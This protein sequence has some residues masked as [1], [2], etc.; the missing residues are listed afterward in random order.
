MK[1]K[2]P[3]ARLFFLGGLL[4]L[5]VSC[6]HLAEMKKLNPATD[7]VLLDVC[8]RP[9]VKTPHR[10]VH[11]IEATFP[12]NRSATMLGVTVVD[13]GRQVLHS[14]LMTL[15]GLVLFDGESNGATLSVNRAVAPFDKESFAQ[16][17]MDDVRLLFLAPAS[18]D[19]EHGVLKDG[20]TLCRSKGN[21]G[22]T[23]DVLI[24]PD[25]TWKI[26]TYKTPSQPLREIIASK[27]TGNIPGDIAFQGYTP[28]VYTLHLTLIS[29]EPVSGGSSPTE[30]GE[31]T[32]NE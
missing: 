32:N 8:G 4:V 2:T 27:L 31:E 24:R 28:R 9:Y 17:M 22:E 15:E 3:A 12:G 25:R 16:N 29:A 23:V 18:P 5:L 1:R 30:T 10:F 13:P 20:T 11:A 21:T 26:E 6:G 14:V 19:P 7:Q